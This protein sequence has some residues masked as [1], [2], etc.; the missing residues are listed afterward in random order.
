MFQRSSLKP[1]AQN[2][3]SRANAK[4]AFVNVT[5]VTWE[6]TAVKKISVL[7]L[8]ARMED[9]VLWENATAQPNS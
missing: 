6:V 3:A 4:Q 7:E 5:L 1:R 8:T 9:Y 2:L